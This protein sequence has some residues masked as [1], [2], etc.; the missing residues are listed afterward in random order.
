MFSRNESHAV[1]FRL[2]QA[3]GLFSCLGLIVNAYGAELYGYVTLILS[4]A[5]YLVLFDFG[6]ISYVRTAAAQQ[7][8]LHGLEAAYEVIF[9]GFKAL[10]TKGGVIYLVLLTLVIFSDAPANWIF[11]LLE[12]PDFADISLIRNSLLYLLVYA[13]LSAAGNLLLAGL[14][15]DGKQY[16]YYRLMAL[17]V[18]IQIAACFWAVTTKAEVDTVVGAILISGHLPI[19]VLLTRVILACSK[20]RSADKLSVENRTS[21]LFL[22]LSWAG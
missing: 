12:A 11:T 9:S 2:L 14:S 16:R 20:A 15:A 4:F 21:I 22:L 7:N 1:A 6:V 17:G 8:E 13:A 5:A 10:A 18:L 3:I 19:V